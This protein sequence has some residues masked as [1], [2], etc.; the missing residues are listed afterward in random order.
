MNTANPEA[1][2]SNWS[3]RAGSGPRPCSAAELAD[4]SNADCAYNYGWNPARDALSHA[5]ATI[6]AVAAT[7]AWWLDVDTGNSWNGSPSANS[8]DL[9]GS[10]HSLLAAKLPP[11]GLYSTRYPSALIT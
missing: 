1:G 8:S 9:P 4:A 6:G 11:A 5:T 7:H 2:S 3:T 10:G